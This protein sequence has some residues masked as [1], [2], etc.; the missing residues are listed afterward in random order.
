MNLMSFVRP[1]YARIRRSAE[2][3][4][5]VPEEQKRTISTQGTRSMTILAISFCNLTTLA[6]SGGT[7]VRTAASSLAMGSE[8]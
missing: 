3:Q 6:V 8:P 4:A 2:M 7:H 1:V 5:S